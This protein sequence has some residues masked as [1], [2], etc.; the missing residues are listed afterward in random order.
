M[1]SKLISGLRFVTLLGLA[2]VWVWAADDGAAV[3]SKQCVKC[4]GE[5]GKG[6]GPTAKM[7][8]NQSM[9]DLS[10]KTGMAKYSDQDLNKM[11]S[12]GG[13]AV[14]KSKV[15]PAYKGKLSEGEIKAV[16]AHIKTL[17]K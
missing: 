13:Q 5:R 11:L 6:D 16:I 1:K 14:G 15:M 17:Q 3:Y 10:S 8:K 12:E 9:G 4:H 2:T 7:L